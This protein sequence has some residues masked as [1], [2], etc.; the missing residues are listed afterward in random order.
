[1]KIIF[2]ILLDALSFSIRN[3]LIRKGTKKVLIISFK[4]IG[5]TTFTFPAVEL[6]G[7]KFKDYEI[8]IFCFEDFEEIYKLKFQD[9]HYI[10]FDK[11]KIDL[12][13]RVPDYEVIKSVRKINPSFLFDFT[14]GYWAAFVSMFSGAKISA[15]FN[16][17]YFKN[18]YS[19]F[20]VKRNK[21]H[22]ADMFADVVKL[23]SPD[24]GAVIKKEFPSDYTKNSRILIHPFAG[25]KAKE[26]NLNKFIRLAAELN[27]DYRVEF[28]V[29]KNFIG[30]DTVVELENKGIKINQTESIADLIKEVKDCSVFISNDS[31][32][33][34]IANV[35]GKPTFSIYGPTNPEFSLPFGKNHRYVRK[36]IECSPKPGQQ[37]CFTYGGRFC[38]TFDCMNLLEFNEVKSK[39]MSFFEELDLERK[40]D[41]AGRI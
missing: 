11:S 6:I 32:P 37:Y 19:H 14:S 8:Y 36:T 24:E 9:I 5:D 30:S 20:M 13:S 39:V 16:S 27:I 21:P 3:L 25:W 7:T 41:N 28:L 18:F 26:W 4:L 23:I 22:L 31:G 34:Y 1:M 29:E 2:Q 12:N 15:G 35:L 38:N 40:V 10:T 17:R 33:L